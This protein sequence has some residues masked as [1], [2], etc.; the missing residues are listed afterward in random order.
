MSTQGA[1]SLWGGS[2]STLSG[3]DSNWGIG[4]PFSSG[5]NNMNLLGYG[6]NSSLSNNQG[7]MQS[8]ASTLG[9]S[10]QAIGSYKGG[11]GAPGTL[12]PSQSTNKPASSIGNMQG[13]LPVSGA[14]PNGPQ[15]SQPSGSFTTSQSPGPNIPSSQGNSA[16]GNV[17][18]QKI[19][20]GNASSGLAI[21][22]ATSIMNSAS[23]G[24]SAQSSDNLGSS[25]WGVPSTTQDSRLSGTS[26][27]GNPTGADWDQPSNASVSQSQSQLPPTTGSQFQSSA[28]GAP[29]G[30]DQQRPS[31]W[32]QAAGKGLNLQANNPNPQSNMSQEEVQRQALIRT[33]IES[34][35][36]WGKKPIRQDTEWSIETSPK[37]QR[38]ISTASVVPDQ[39]K[40]TNNMWNNNN[41]T[42]IWEAN[43]DNMSAWGGNQS[44]Q[45]RA[46][47]QPPSNWPGTQ[48]KPPDPAGGAQWGVGGQG[49]APGPDKG[50]GPWGAPGN[51]SNTNWGGSTETGS[52]VG[53]F[54]SSTPGAS[55]GISTWGD[56]DGTSSWGEGRNSGGNDGTSYWGDPSMKPPVQ[57]PN[58][59]APGSGQQAIGQNRKMGSGWGDPMGPPDP[60]IDD[61]TG[62][63]NSNPQPQMPGRPA[64]W[65]GDA[66]NPQW[67][68]G[69]IGKPNPKMVGQNPAQYGGVDELNW[70]LPKDGA[71]KF[72]GTTGGNH[73]PQMRSRLL[74]QLMDMGFKKD[75]AQHALITNNMNI[76][77]AISDLYN[78]RGAITSKKDELEMARMSGL[79]PDGS[80]SDDISDTQSDSNSFVPNMNPM[81]NTPYTN[82]QSKM[83]SQYPFNNGPSLNQSS[84][85]SN[86]P[87][88]NNAL[89]Q[90]IMQK[91]QSQQPPPPSPSMNSINQAQGPMGRGQLPAGQQ[92]PAVH[93][94]MAQQQILQQLRMA[95]Q[96]GLIS[97]QLLNQ[98]LPAPV[99]VMLQ[100]LLQ[101]QQNLQQLITTQQMLQQPKVNMNPHV[102]RQ[103]MESVASRINQIKQQIL[104]LQKNISQAQL[105]NKTQSQQQPPH[106]QQQHQQ[107]PMEGSESALQNELNNLSIS[108]TQPQ[109]RL[110]QWKRPTP[111]KESP[112]ITPATSNE[113]PTSSSTPITSSNSEGGE[114]LNKTV[115]SKSV[116]QS[117]SQPN[118]RRF[119]ELGLTQ[120]GGDTTWSTSAS[121]A[122]Q[123]WP[124]SSSP[125]TSGSSGDG[126]Q[127][128][129]KESQTTTVSSSSGNSSVLDSMTSIPEFVP[130]KPWQGIPKNV[131][132]DPHITPGSFSRSLSVNTIKD[133]YLLTLTKSSPTNDSNSSW[134]SKPPGGNTTQSMNKPW[135]AG[136]SLTP[137]S[138]TSDVWG[139]PKGA[140]SRPPPGLPQQ[141]KGGWTGM[142]RQQSWAGTSSRSDGGSN[143]GN[144]SISTA[145][146]LK[147]LT[148]QIDG[149]TLRTLCMQHGPLQYFYLNLAHGQALVKYRSTEEAIK[150]Q[151]S[152]NTCL[153]G[154]TTIV[155]EFVSEVEALR[156]VE[157][158]SAMSSG[159]SQWS[160]MGQPRQSTAI[161]NQRQDT[162]MS[163]GMAPPTSM[164]GTGMWGNSSVGSSGT[165]WDNIEDNSTHNLLG[166]M[167]GDNM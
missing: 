85:G 124:N 68:P 150:A 22:P 151:K 14:Q 137:T 120:L 64:G 31:S 75:E 10:N 160:Q 90:K 139:V 77:N 41:G 118:L 46:P 165:L 45:A 2:S 67:N 13:S 17:G 37:V 138:F 96:A 108:S 125:V 48:Q 4:T 103:Q 94:Q 102:Q 156:F 20:T 107:P 79:L 98:Q 84:L 119:D 110:N 117:N 89:Q 99:L 163:W 141:N 111:D 101:Q 21:N 164:S 106:Q 135:S 61:G 29:A 5:A 49:Q 92:N 50:M 136:E 143:W 162:S 16:F 86:N 105:L 140:M 158:Q 114:S 38:K 63:W 15:S 146:L 97:P 157:Q 23:N 30:Q 39:Q 73:P 58:W 70:N 145:L 104:M 52:W 149:S 112:E 155:A 109:S 115:G 167:L 34:H 78:R 95:V 152:L 1:S 144:S 122:S 33:A 6:G 44:V 7:H 60:K 83:P 24:S 142:N 87:S 47:G 88:I 123:N 55:G 133:D 129:N 113:T 121:S 59:N 35:D 27:W 147:N 62:L 26:S 8:G 153:L 43:K 57:Q 82:A 131:E 66:G 72:P 166:N 116:Q 74:Q 19:P 18:F 9:D 12:P 11:W 134:P 51:Q 36:G 80:A 81:Q 32:A 159:P 42:A 3:L 76:Q 130:G 28:P 53:N 65:G 154:N 161:G 148:P 56:A 25:G 128:D 40:G 71:I 126:G 91:F 69:A 132:D 100:Q 93:Q 54:G 127:P